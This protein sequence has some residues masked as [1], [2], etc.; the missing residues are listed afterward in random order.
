MPRI[1]GVDI[2]PNKKILYSLQYVYGIGQLRSALILKEAQIQPTKLAKDLSDEDYKTLRYSVLDKG[3]EPKE[4][5]NKLKGILESYEELDPEE[6]KKK[7]YTTTINRFLSTLRNLRREIEHS[8]ML[9]KK[10]IREV[11][12]LISRIEEEM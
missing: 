12:Q 6:E 7:R 2:P 5:R 4:V 8:G 3:E 1:S 9:S 11:D 10:I